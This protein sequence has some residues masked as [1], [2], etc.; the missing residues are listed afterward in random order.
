M[1]NSIGYKLVLELKEAAH[2]TT[3]P[4]L[5]KLLFRAANEIEELIEELKRNAVKKP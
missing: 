5:A 1:S 2:D 4:E 3:K